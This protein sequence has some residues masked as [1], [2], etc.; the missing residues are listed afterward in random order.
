MKLFNSKRLMFFCYFSARSAAA[1]VLRSIICLFL[2]LLSSCGYQLKHYENSYL[3]TT[4]SVPFVEGDR[5]GLLT[6]EIVDALVE[7]GFC[8]YT[9]NGGNLVL[10][11]RVVSEILDNVGFRYE[12]KDKKNSIT[13]NKLI[14]PTETRLILSLEVSVYSHVEECTILPPF[15]LIESVVFDH[16][17]YTTRNKDN[18]FSLG[19][20]TEFEEA[21][22]AALR[23][24]YKRMAKKLTDY[25]KQQ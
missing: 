21:Q 20:L 25:L 22:T 5:D 19:Q 4:M 16:D 18:I 24:L 6:A 1:T 10:K 7:E 2:L 12:K 15:T 23:P 11:A 8:R 14:I 9:P 3:N 13:T 17:Y